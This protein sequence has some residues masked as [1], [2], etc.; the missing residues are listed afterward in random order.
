VTPDALL[1][2]ALV[3]AFES[4][5]HIYGVA[6]DH[7]DYADAVR[8]IEGEATAATDAIL[9]ALA[10]TPPAS[11]ER[12]ALIGEH[13]K[14]VSEWSGNFGGHVGIR[15]GWVEYDDETPTDECEVCDLIL[16]ATPPASAERDAVVADGLLYLCPPGECTH[17][18]RD[19]AFRAAE[20]R[21]EVTG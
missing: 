21:D 7:S 5:T 13:R 16:A 12:E 8:E 17:C 4:L 9:T 6:T 11:A 2:E 10:A 18:D 1:R 3:H 20:A 15:D 19:R 14:A